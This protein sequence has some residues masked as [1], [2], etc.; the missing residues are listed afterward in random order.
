MYL[1][2]L[3]KMKFTKLGVKFGELYTPNIEQ[4]SIQVLVNRRQ[5]YPTTSKH[6]IYG[7]DRDLVP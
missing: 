3:F 4:N 6:N 7:A 5:D 2:R 1:P